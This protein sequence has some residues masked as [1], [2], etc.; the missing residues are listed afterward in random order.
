VKRRTGKKTA[1]Q[2]VVG[3]LGVGLDSRDEHKR[4]TQSEHFVLLGGSSETHER[5][6]DT[7]MRFEEAL[8]RTGKPLCETPA[9]SAADL[10]REAMDS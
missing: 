5:M 4:I 1:G 10:L 2:E 8:K 9:D 7:V 3:F 6:Q